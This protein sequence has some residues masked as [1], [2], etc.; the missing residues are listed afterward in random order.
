MPK[1]TDIKKI[2]I[3][4]SG[5]IV[6]GQACEFDYSGT[7]AC[8][9]LR[10]EGYEVVLVN[11]NP[12]TI[13]T[14]PELAQRT[15]IEPLTK[16]FVEAIIKRERPDALLPTVGGQTALNI[17]VELS[18]SGVLDEYKVEM[19]GAKADAVKMAEDRLLFKQAM[20]AIGLATPKSEVIG[21]IREAQRVVESIGF[22]AIIRPSF[23]L[24]GTGGGIAFNG[25]ELESIVQRGLDL[26]P[27][28]TVLIEESVIGWKEF[29]LEVMRDLKD[30]V[31]VICSIENFDPMG[32]HTGDS[33]TVAPVQTLTDREYQRL[34]DAAAAV[35]RQIG[36]ETGGSNIQF[37]VNP[38]NGSLV[39]IEMN[40]RVSRSSALA[41]KATGFPIAKI[42][43][44]L[45]VGYTLNEIPNDI[46]KKTP[47]SFEP[48]LD[49][50]VVKIPKWAF[51]KFPESD[52]TLGTQM[53]SVGEVMAIGRTFKEAFLK[54]VR[55]LETGKEPGSEVIDKDRIRQKLITPTPDRIPYLL[56]AVGNG[57]SI[58]ELV[59]MTHIDPWFL[60]EMKEIADL[61]KEVSA[62][63]LET[64]PVELLR[65]AKRAGL[66]DSHLARFLGTKASAVA[67]KRAD[68]GIIPVYKR[69]DTCAAEFES[70]TP[71]FYSTYEEEDEGSPSNTKK[72]II[73]G[74]GP[75]RIGQGIEFDYCCCHASFALK[76]EGY[77]TIMV[78]CNPET[79]S[80]DYDTSD[81]LYFEP[82]TLEDVLHIVKQEKPHGVIVQFGGQT[83]LNLA[84][85]LQYAGV[86]I[87]GTSPES[88]DL[89]ED[90]KRFGDL[91]RKLNIPQPQNG[92]A[93]TLEEARAVARQIGYPVLVRPSYVLGGRAMVIVYDE[94]TLENYMSAAVQVSRERPILIDK[95]LE[96]AYEVDV[97]ALCD[98]EEVVIGGIMEHIEE[99]GV[100]SGDSSCVLPTY[101]LNEDLRETI[102]RHTVVLGRALNVVGLMNIQFAV[103]AGTVYVLEV[104]PRASRTVPFVSKATGVPL[105]KLAAKLMV[106]RKLRDFGLSSELKVDQYC[107]KSPVFPFARFLGSDTILGPEMKSTGE[108]MGI[109]D[110]FGKAYVKAQISAGSVLPKSGVAFI[111]VNQHDKNVI[112][113]IAADLVEIG[114][115]IVASRGTAQV[116]RN[117][118]VRAETVYKVNEGRPHIVDYIKSGK[119]DLIINTPLGRE[120]FFDEKAIRR[121]AIHHHVPCITTIPGA[122]AAVNGIRALQRESLNVRTLQEYHRKDAG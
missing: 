31:V 61:M 48:M 64:L 6:I 44:K 78:N 97:D 5:P 77:E 113:K 63:K 37:A 35:I 106:G 92:T 1:R 111:S 42:A 69:V 99:A 120:S 94:S 23:T 122:A 70:Y 55:S 24:G 74:S 30:N 119:V 53:K 3:I 13:M 112:S 121:A 71:Y 110:T 81:R 32:V 47:A 89:A 54:A 11:S 20:N 79:V 95:F 84:L 15:Y 66:S 51:E 16:E 46:T 115:K 57:F 109:D 68:Y 58:D 85:D 8:K 38:K 14:D 102:R 116:L 4:G 67:A 91:L 33:I 56:H 104:N 83:P 2:L 10:E 41:S 93:V 103:R 45:A 87:I 43:A 117:S 9:A 18:D 29:E 65:E 34:R 98:D 75:N 52:P 17:A 12:A 7:Q 19:I 105:A 86:P 26:S 76:E 88:I 108:V 101:Q 60:N 72:V 80:T 50:V 82:L 62:Y 73:L 100:H 59:E 22:P 27:V 40:P 36:V 28:H 25:E 107:V 90:R 39:V 21:D 49:Y 96:D 114:F 118:G